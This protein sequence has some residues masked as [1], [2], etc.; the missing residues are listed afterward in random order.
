MGPYTFDEVVS[1]HLNLLPC[2]LGKNHG[3]RNPRVSL[4]H[5]ARFSGSQP[6]R[7][8][9]PH[10]NRAPPSVFTSPKKCFVSM[11]F[12][13]SRQNVSKENTDPI[14]QKAEELRKRAEAYAP[15]QES[16]QTN[17]ARD[18]QHEEEEYT[19]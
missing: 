5:A 11:P 13:S 15:S 17:Y 14:E 10:E 4:K 12:S 2:G 3:W 7:R 6:L 1:L 9:A 18:L 19:Q 16:L 8:A